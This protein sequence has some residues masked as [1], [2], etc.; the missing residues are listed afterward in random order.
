MRNILMRVIA[1]LGVLSAVLL[2]GCGGSGGSDAADELTNERLFKSY[3][4]STYYRYDANGNQSLKVTGKPFIA[5]R[6]LRVDPKQATDC[7]FGLYDVT[8][9]EII[10]GTVH[11]NEIGSADIP[12]D[13]HFAFPLNTKIIRQYKFG[14][15]DNFVDSNSVITV[16]E[17]NTNWFFTLN[18]SSVKETSRITGTAIKIN[19][20]GVDSEGNV[21]K[22]MDATPTQP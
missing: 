4:T 1:T 10:A 11:E 13:S 5:V 15:K 14:S 19:N 2:S 16:R 12:F 22:A 7:F 17:N 8:Q 20:F 3:S 9:Q 18:D 21:F 6:Y